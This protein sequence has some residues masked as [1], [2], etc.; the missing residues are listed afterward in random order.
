MDVVPTELGRLMERVRRMAFDGA[1]LEWTGAD[2]DDLEPLLG[3]MGWA[4]LGATG[5]AAVDRALSELRSLPRGE[6]RDRARAD[7]AAALAATAPLLFLY[8]A[9]DV[10]LAARRLGDVELDAAP[11]AD[12][13]RLRD[14]ARR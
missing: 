1:V 5:S 13:F 9:D 2:E 12:F 6:A 4:A 14:L 10:Y 8:A 7:L 11:G 3:T